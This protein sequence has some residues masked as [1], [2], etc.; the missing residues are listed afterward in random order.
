[1]GPLKRGDRVEHVT[2]A[3]LGVGD[4]RFVE[5]IADVPMAY[6]VWSGTTELGRYACEQLRPVEDLASLLGKAGPGATVPFQLRVLGRWF[7][8]RHEQTGE[9]TNQPFDMLPHQVIVTNRVLTSPPAEDGGRH[10][11]IA[12]DVGLGKTIEAGMI[13]EVMRHRA[14]GALRC[15]VVAPAGLVSQWQ[16]ELAERFGRRF[17]RFDSGDVNRL[18]AF[19]QLVASIDT[20]KI[21]RYRAAALHAHAWDLVVFDEAHHL[22]RPSVLMYDLAREMREKKKCKN[23]IFLTATPHSGNHDHFCN[24]LHLLRPD[25]VDRPTKRLKALPDLPLARMIIRN[26]K[27]LVT[28]ARG[29]KIFHGVAKAMIL[30]FQPTRAEVELAEEVK[31]YLKHGYDEAGKLDIQGRSAVGFLMSTFGKLASSSREA[32]KAALQ[33]RLDLLLRGMEDTISS[34]DDVLPGEN[35][36]AAVGGATRKGKKGKQSLI[37]DEAKFV[38]ALLDRLGKLPGPDS[39]LDGFA[40]ELG[41][42]VERTPDVKMLIFTEYRATQEVLA[43]RLADLFG[44]ESVDTIHGSKKLD[45]RKEVVRRF[46]ENEQPRFIVSTAAGGEGLNLQQRCHTIVNYDLP[47]NPNVLQQRIGRVY[48]YGQRRP[49]VVYNLRVDTDS[50][51]FA[52]NKVYE[53]LEKRIGDVVDALS[54]ATGEGEEDLLGDVLGQAAVVGLSLEELHEIAIKEG[55][56]R[57]RD[58]INEKAKH[59]E[60]IMRNP[61]MIGMFRGLP[62]FNLDDYNKV[63]SQVTSDHLAFFVKQYCECS[64]EGL[65]YRDEEGKRFSFTPSQKLAELAAE[66]Q[67]RDPYAVAGK[68]TTDKVGNAT[69]DK[70]VA[71]SGARLLRFGDPVFEAMVQHVQYRDFSAVASLDMPAD[72]LG[73]ESRQQGVWMMF[74]LQVTRTEGRRSLVLRRE[75]ASF[76]VAV[77]GDLAK[78]TPELVEHV[79]KATQGP[80]RVDIEEARRGFAI[81]FQA[82]KARLVELR[83]EVRAEYPGDEAIAPVPVSEFALAWVRAV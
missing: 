78:P 45:A 58:T 73:W 2:D 47:W 31:T 25:L 42:L 11:L 54:R 44:K 22:T 19:D 53:Y 82:A 35:A 5:E 63:Q 50:N 17:E 33:G 37:H 15:L 64:K 40:R 52:D 26:R 71:Q 6:V 68:V 20:L 9:I 83:D 72:S 66:R 8:A 16:V 46:N 29:T 69:V 10:W 80:P 7:Q 75:L 79:N 61:E 60:E 1:M 4:V 32:L 55:E 43:N 3:S 23:T 24:M 28:D 62:R 39:K 34:V 41:K 81:G 57:V 48:R 14:G 70:E 12:D 76:V 38:G 77:G 18:E 59:L 13:L 67:R 65:G 27:H 51:A 49:V 21:P 30:P 74:E 56:A 36:V